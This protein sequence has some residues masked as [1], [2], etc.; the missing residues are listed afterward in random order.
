MKENPLRN[1]KF[2]SMIIKDKCVYYRRKALSKYVT[3]KYMIKTASKYGEF[4]I[5][6][7]LYGKVNS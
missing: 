4:C 1:D 2:H 7:T 5:E 6:E 3:R